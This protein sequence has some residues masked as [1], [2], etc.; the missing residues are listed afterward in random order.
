MSSAWCGLALLAFLASPP[1]ICAASWS[2]S[3]NDHDGLPYIARDGTPAVSSSY[4]FW[5]ANW[6]WADQQTDFRIIGAYDYAVSGRNPTLNADLSARISRPGVG[7]LMWEFDLEA[8]STIADAI[9]GG[10]VFKFDLDAFA[11]EMGEPELLPRGQ[12]WSWGRQGQ[13]RIVMRFDP[14]LAS[15]HFERSH[16]S[17]IRALFYHQGV[18]AGKRRIKAVIEVSGDIR[19]EQTAGERFGPPDLQAWQADILDWRNSP[20]DLSFLN[21]TEKPAG[22]RGFIRASG[23]MLV[24]DDGT[25]GRF[26][27]TN[28]TA[29]ALFGTPK[30]AVRQQARRLSQ[31]GFNLVRLH[32]HDS[33]WVSPNIFGDDKAPTTLQPSPAMQ[34]KLD[35][36]IA[37]LKDEGIYIWLDLHVQRHVKPADNIEYF[38]EIARGKASTELK[39]YNYVNDS[40]RE[41]MKRFNEAY[42]GHV[43][44]FTGKAYKDEPA[45][46]AMLITN[47]N[48]V[49]QHFGNALLPDKQVP[50]HNETFMRMAASFADKHQLPRDKVWRA[51]EHGPPKLFLNELERRFNTE[52]LAHLRA[53]GVRVPI[54]TTSSWGLNPLSSLPALT[55][56]DIIDV[57]S[58]GAVEDIGRNPLHQSNLVSWMAAAHVSGKPLS[59][60]E[61]NAGRFPAADRHGLPLYVAASAGMQ[62]WD[63]MM[64]YAYSQI[65]LNSAGYPSNW[66]AYNDPGLLAT[67][68][69]AALL[70]R[71]KH[72]R[73]A[74]SVYAFAPTAERL[75]GAAMSPATSVAL[76][77]AVDR[78][79]LLVALPATRELAWLRQGA[80]PAGAHTLRDPAQALIPADATAVDSDNGE[81]R[82][83]WGNG[84]FTIST[85]F[86][87]AAT[88]WIGGKNLDLGDAHI[89]ITT[90]NASIAVQSLDGEPIRTS[91]NIL[92]SLGA[93]SLPETARGLPF[94]SE[95]V[96]GE[97]S[98]GAAPGLALYALRTA[99]GK[100]DRIAAPYVNGRYTIALGPSLKTYWLQ[101]RP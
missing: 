17:E 39:G 11:R 100:A 7:Q 15:I 99:G 33:A 18:Q 49:T 92:I 35:W 21:E 4:A 98:I 93:R 85:P 59:V 31:L 67:M 87:R 90:R 95:P 88:G 25:P 28:L 3:V 89:R 91:R 36:W 86:T 97:L 52:M 58:Y 79:K 56:G 50:R 29:A 62:G 66:H 2:L 12:G 38:P 69:A 1:G 20:V 96:A 23:D 46:M 30:D 53:L 81:L 70:Y 63:A 22:R 42:V 14:P 44:R 71:R 60:T 40:L 74:S 16:K 68:P 72:V 65:P 76:R 34:E 8:R 83:D 26:W 9:G 73:E 24:F 10:V 27:G 78:G 101:L 64:Q 19:V 75:F 6:K 77:T 82:R 37:C 47:E 80:I 55:L 5:G 54:A 41:A 43:N 45:I 48:D 32:H 84:V 94:R 61:W 13:N 57:H 51:W